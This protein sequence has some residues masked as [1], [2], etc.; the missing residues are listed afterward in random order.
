MIN[1]ENI[2]LIFGLKVSL[3]RQARGLS[4][5]ELA[6]MAGLSPS[7]V[8][9]IEKGKKYPKAD[10]IPALAAALGTSYDYLISLQIDDKRVEP[11]I[12]LLRSNVLSVLP[13]R[14]FGLEPGNLV[15]IATQA[16]E[17]I[18]AFVNTVAKIARTYNFSM[19]DF[20][21]TA[22]RSYQE[23]NRNYFAELEEAAAVFTRQYLHGRPTLEALEGYLQQEHRYRYGQ[24]DLLQYPQLSGLRMVLRPGKEPDLLLNPGLSP[25]QKLFVLA[26]EVGYS[27]LK[28][29]ERSLSYSWQDPRDFDT[30][31][32]NFKA[33]YFAGALLM[34]EKDF[35]ADIKAFFASASWQPEALGALVHKWG[36][37]PEMFLHRMTSV[38]P[39]RLGIERLFFLRISQPGPD[40]GAELTKEI[41]LGGLHNP[42]RGILNE[43][44]CRRWVALD[45]IKQARLLQDHGQQGIVCLP[46]TSTYYSN[47]SQYFIIS[48]AQAAGGL[49]GKFQSSSIGMYVDEAL[50]KKIRFLNDPAIRHRMVDETCERCAAVD[51]MERAAPAVFVQT[52]AEEASLGRYIQEVIDRRPSSL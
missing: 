43:H 24:L 15:E 11:L 47:G 14:L 39:Q 19:E 48:M 26:R 17:R 37:S 50:R 34:P 7:Y 40:M 49:S 36:V 9:E 10:K 29:K 35:T 41:H 27:L 31:L 6:Q 30:L 23:L 46:Q 28:L 18:G 38:L 21:L 22:L 4:S 33:T 12:A 16:P 13:L 52:N 51:C 2:R 3:L 1:D 45:T 44:Y 32:N 20:F 42:H 25:A 8:T 5:G